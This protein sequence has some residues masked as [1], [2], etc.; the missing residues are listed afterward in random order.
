MKKPSRKR[1]RSTN[2]RRVIVTRVL[3]YVNAA[4]W[5]V[6]GG[7]FITKM[8]LDA[9][10]LIVGLVG[11]FFFITILLLIVAARI[12]V[13]RENWAYIT[14]I[15]ITLVNIILTFTGFPDVLYIVALLIDA[16]ILATFLPLKTYYDQ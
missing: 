15:V 11:F 7:I 14:V 8:L 2:E 1:N 16:V 5:L 12:L 10:G 3:L 6:L 4:L 9:N 13:T